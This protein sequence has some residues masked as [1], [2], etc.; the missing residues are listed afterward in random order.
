MS[1]TF[2]YTLSTFTCKKIYL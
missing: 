1:T 2:I